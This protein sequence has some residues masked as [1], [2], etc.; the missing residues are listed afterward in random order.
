MERGWWERENWFGVCHCRGVNN[1]ELWYQ[2]RMTSC[3]CHRE[4]EDVVDVLLIH[5]RR[6]RSLSMESKRMSWRYL[7]CLLCF[8][9]CV[10]VGVWVGW[11]AAVVE[12]VMVGFVAVCG[13]LFVE[14]K[15]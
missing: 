4:E 3:H 2:R 6:R 14:E 9:R 5:V 12:A 1:F 10:V 15:Y 13:L 7:I 11:S 8:R